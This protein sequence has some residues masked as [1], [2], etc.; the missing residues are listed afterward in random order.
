MQRKQI[1]KKQEANVLMQGTT[2]SQQKTS[3]TDEQEW[4]EVC[5]KIVPRNN[6]EYK[7]VYS[8]KQEREKDPMDDTGTSVSRSIHHYV[9][10]RAIGP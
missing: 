4:H 2:G 9:D 3:N 10:A 7:Y 5:L 8:L 6:W 1:N